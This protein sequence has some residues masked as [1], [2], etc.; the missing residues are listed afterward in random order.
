MCRYL[1]PEA[2]RTCN[3]TRAFSGLER[4]LNELDLLFCRI[5]IHVVAT[6]ITTPASPRTAGSVSEVERRVSVGDLLASK[7]SP[8]PLPSSPS[9][10]TAACHGSTQDLQLEAP[11]RLRLDTEV[12]VVNRHDLAVCAPAC[13]QNH[14]RWRH[15]FATP[16]YGTTVTL[17][18]HAKHHWRSAAEPEG[19]GENP[20]SGSCHRWEAALEEPQPLVSPLWTPCAACMANRPPLKAPA[21]YQKEKRCIRTKPDHEAL[22]VRII[23]ARL[24]P[25]VSKHSRFL[26][27]ALASC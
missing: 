21:A 9:T 14:A 3:F 12:V 4:H 16:R 10:A 8:H 13:E 25:C 26:P 1:R 7:F 6:L 2:T 18:S 5:H 24:R 22:L 19:P 23:H 17:P 20:R 11:R 15:D 27:P